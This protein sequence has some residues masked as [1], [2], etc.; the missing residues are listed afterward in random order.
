MNKLLINSENAEY[1]IIQ[2]LKLNR[3]KRCKSREIFIEG[4]E[5]IKQAINSNIEITR[6]IVKDIKCLSNWGKNIIKQ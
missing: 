4:I 1:Q 2:S 5:C 6:I 3:V